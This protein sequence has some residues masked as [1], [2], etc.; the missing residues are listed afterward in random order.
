MKNVVKNLNNSSEINNVNSKI[1]L[2]CFHTVVHELLN[3]INYSI[4]R[5]VFPTSW[6]ESLFVP[7]QKVSGTVFAN[8]FRPIN[9]L[10]IF[11]KV[12]ETVVKEQLVEYINSNHL[13]IPEQSGYRVGHYCESALNLVLVKWKEAFDGKNT[14]IVVFLDL[15]RA[16][17]TISRPLLLKVL[18][19]F[20]I[21]GNE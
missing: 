9:K 21:K 3:I 1:L 4:T 12:L 8:E 6:K 20:G 18:M 5:G 7:I 10:N 11:E 13:F 19:S 2:D 15:K 17:E 16:F 14:T